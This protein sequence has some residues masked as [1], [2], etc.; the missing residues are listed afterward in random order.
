MYNYTASIKITQDTVRGLLC[1]AFEGGSN[2]WYTNVEPLDFPD[3][4]SLVDY[5]QGGSMQSQD[6]YWHWSQLIPTTGGS[7][8]VE[9]V[10][11]DVFHLD[12]KT[13]QSGLSLMSTKYEKHFSDVLTENYDATTGDVFLQLCLFKEIVYG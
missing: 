2:Y 4:K 5:A 11:N 12:D 1:T 13:I 6:N 3:G 7:V 8:K 10:D 9:T